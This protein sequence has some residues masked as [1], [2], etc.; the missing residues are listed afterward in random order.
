MASDMTTG[1]D[2]SEKKRVREWFGGG[3][4]SRKWELE[5]RV[6]LGG[7]SRTWVLEE[8]LVVLTSN[9]RGIPSSGEKKLGSI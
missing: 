3:E 7:D 9:Y 8:R 5:F 2:C 4:A 1:R 6:V